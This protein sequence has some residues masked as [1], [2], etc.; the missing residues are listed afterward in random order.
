MNRDATRQASIIRPMDQ[1][2]APGRRASASTL[3]PDLM[4]DAVK[5]LSAS[6]FIY[7]LGFFLAGMLPALVYPAA[8]AMFFRAEQHWVPPTLSIAVALL[9]MY[10]VS[11]PTVTDRTKLRLGLGFQVLGSFGISA[12]EFQRIV[13]PIM[14]SV[15]PGGFGLSWVVTWVLLF[16]V[17]VPTPPR[18]AALA[19]AFSVAMVPITYAI[20]VALGSNVA[21]R[22]EEFFFSL[23]FPYMVVVVMAY[24]ASRVVFSLGTAVRKARELGSYRLEERL[25]SGGMGEVWRARHRMLA[26]PAAIK[27]IRPEALGAEHSR[28]ELLQRFERE[29][30]ATS[31]LRS[32]HT[33]EVYDF[34][35][36][37]DGSF[38]YV[39]ELLDGFDLESLVDRFGP[40]P[41]ERVVH[42]LLQACDS[43]GEAHAAGLLHRDIK[44][45]NLYACRHGRDVDFVKVLDF[46]LVEQVEAS[47]PGP[48][49]GRRRMMVGTPAFMSPE[50][51]VGDEAVDARSD[52]YSIGC[53][54]FWLLTGR[55]VFVGPTP[56]DTMLMHVSVAP[57][58]PSSVAA[59]VPG[60]LDA[61]VLECL[62]KE[63]FDRPQ[64]VDALA[65]RLGALALDGAWTGDR[66]QAWWNAHAP[67][68]SSSPA[69]AS[70]RVL[71]L[72]NSR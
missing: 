17:L 26:R 69:A 33:V 32:A 50:Q 37:D 72:L 60:A 62:A 5:R 66:A 16:S 41:A 40:Q 7:A 36:T 12:A 31:L 65:A 28:E 44:P 68:A 70:S 10:I 29:A 21:L 49:T 25:G 27:L 4:A 43:I 42:L 64:T 22:A 58:R 3:P 13:A 46:G 38:Y 45:A 6:L 24:V 39:M 2:S 19:A 1:A 20:G 53:V 47:G 63:P 18:L 56:T 30:Q 55:P 23:V 8:R 61:V 15:G 57:D 48:G 59:G 35:A 51:V 9:L 54:A 52:I 34:G 14:T 71:N 11:R 67:P